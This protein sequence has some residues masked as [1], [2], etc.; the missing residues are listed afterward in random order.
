MILQ[1]DA[2]EQKENKPYRSLLIF[3]IKL[4]NMSTDCSDDGI[5]SEEGFFLKMLRMTADGYPY[6]CTALVTELISHDFPSVRVELS[7]LE[8]RFISRVHG[9]LMLSLFV[10]VIETGC[11]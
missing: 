2:Q 5:S 8:T 6:A 3:S 9:V 10:I 7:G 11:Y 4:K 1:C